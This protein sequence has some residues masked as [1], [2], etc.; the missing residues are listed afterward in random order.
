V[1]SSFDEF[2]GGWPALAG[3]MLG[4]GAGLGMFGTVSGFFVKPLQ[5]EFGWGRGEIA[6]SSAAFIATSLLMPLIGVLVDRK[7]ARLFV[8]IGAA[9]FAGCYVALAMMPGE[10]WVYIAILAVVGLLAGPA[11]APLVFTRPVVE[12][13]DSQRGLAIALAMSGSTLIAVAALPAL[14]WLIQTHGWRAGYWAMAPFSLLLGGLSFALFKVSEARLRAHKAATTA[15]PS[16]SG[17]ALGAAVR[18]ARFWLLALTMIFAN[19][20]VGAAGGQLQPLLSDKGVP[21]VTAALLGSWYAAMILV[22][23]LVV[24][25]MLDRFWPPMVA[26]ISLAGP[27]VGLLLLAGDSAAIAVLMVAITLM[28]LAQGAEG[29]LLAF[30]TARLFGLRAFG[31]IFGVLGLL[32]GVSASI[33]GLMGGMMFDHFGNYQLMLQIGS[34]LSVLSALSI[35]LLGVVRRSASPEPALT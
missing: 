9:I 14:Q 11:T 18:D 19:M 2:R 30:F 34:V 10:L 23:R 32:Y 12:A 1:K 3:A 21:G 5:A 29:D 25:S 6:L 17:V 28:A 16:L 4:M 35:L 22:G 15:A 13:F 26:A 24:G 27:V 33:G 20:A 8:G 31:S 7:G